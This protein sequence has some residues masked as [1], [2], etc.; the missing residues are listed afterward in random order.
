MKLTDQQL[1]LV[2]RFCLKDLTKKEEKLLRQIPDWEEAVSFHKNFLGAFPVFKTNEIKNKLRFFEEELQQEQKI[3][4]KRFGI[5]NKIKEQV[6]LT[7]DEIANLFQP[8]PNYQAIL[9]M[10]SRSGNLI[11]EE[12]KS[13][14]NTTNNLLSFVLKKKPT[15]SLQLTIENNL[16]E[17]LLT[18]EISKN[19]GQSFEVPLSGLQ[20]IPGRYYWRL[21]MNGEVLMDEFFIQKELLN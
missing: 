21:V 15:H 9:A 17:I 8:V 14:L 16:Q 11:I 3:E 18:R 5:L 10:A 1:D 19:E 2:E 12:P 13:G 20:N 6:N 4:K 7:L